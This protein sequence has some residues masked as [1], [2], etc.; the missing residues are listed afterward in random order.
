MNGTKYDR[1]HAFLAGKILPFGVSAV[2]VGTSVFSV[3]PPV[4]GAP[5]VENLFNN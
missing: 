2:I 1:G 5:I 4:A 3:W